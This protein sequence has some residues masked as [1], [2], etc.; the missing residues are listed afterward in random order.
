MTKMNS[1]ITQNTF[2]P[3]IFITCEEDG[4]DAEKYGKWV[5][6]NQSPEKLDN[7]ISDFLFSRREECHDEEDGI[8]TVLYKKKW[9]VALGSAFDCIECVISR[10]D[11]LGMYVEDIMLQYTYANGEDF[12]DLHSRAKFLSSVSQVA[13]ILVEWGELGAQMIK[14]HGN[15]DD[16]NMALKGRIQ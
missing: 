10:L 15:I 11:G 2:E 9:N 14:H 6:A 3:K 13:N 5:N 1:T 12:E 4:K 16:A 7:E 8:T